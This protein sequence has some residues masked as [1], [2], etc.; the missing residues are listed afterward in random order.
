MKRLITTLGICVFSAAVYAQADSG[1]GIKA[2]VNYN[3]NGSLKAATTQAFNDILAGSKQKMGYH[4]GL[5]AKIDLPLVYLR[6]ELVFTKTSSE[7]LVEGTT[8]SFDRAK[9]DIPVLVGYKLLGPV[10]VFAGPA[11][12]YVIKDQFNDGFQNF[13]LSSVEKNLTLGM[14]LGVG[15]NLNKIGI[16]VRLERG[17][18]ANE[19]NLINTK[20]TDVND[21][22]DSRPRQIIFALSYK[23]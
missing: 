14:Q 6:P 17:L 21:R 9:I 20:I 16:D 8:G 5:Y 1:I 23:L 7:Y 18:S 22:I 12:Q 11:F 10:H 4:V 13:T 19:V 15:V 2:G 3:Q